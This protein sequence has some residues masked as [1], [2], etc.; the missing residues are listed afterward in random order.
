MKDEG[1]RFRVQRLISDAYD[2]LY[3][4]VKLRYEDNPYFKSRPL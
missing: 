3:G 1:N 2:S 4:A